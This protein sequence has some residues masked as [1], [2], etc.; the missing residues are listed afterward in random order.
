MLQRYVLLCLPLAFAVSVD[1]D[2]VGEPEIECGA[3]A[4]GITFTTRKPFH[5]HL[6]VKGRFDDADCKNEQIGRPF[7]GITLHFETCGMS[8]LRSLY[9]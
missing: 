3:D 2:V 1:N 4:I 8:R 9:V 5:G 7:T 6:F